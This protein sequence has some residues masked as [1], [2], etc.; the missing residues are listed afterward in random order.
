LIGNGV[1][2]V[3]KFIGWFFFFF[4]S[5]LAEAIHSVADTFNQI[6]LFIGVKHGQALESEK[7]PFGQGSA[8]YLWNLISAV[9]IFFLGFGITA[10]H[11]FHSLITLNEHPY[12]T[13]SLVGTFI[14]II[15]LIVEGYVFLVALKEVNTKRQRL[16]FFE[17]LNQSDDPTTIAVLL[18][19]GIAVLGVLLA[20]SGLWISKF[21]Q[22]ALPD[23]ITAI[24]IAFLLGFMAL[25]LAYINGRLLIG[26]AAPKT[27]E[28]MIRKFLQQQPEVEKIVKLKTLILGPERV[29]LT[30]ELELHGTAFIDRQ[31]IIND[32]EKIKNGEEPTPIL[33]D[34]SE[35]MIRLIGKG[36]N[37][38]EKRIYSRFPSIV[39]IDLE[40]N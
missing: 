18:E 2:T 38:L 40:V 6:L 35:R 5:I 25:A 28:A 3:A 27:S 19:D 4:P 15:A 11:G 37:K 34:T 13:P 36:I 7:Y 10:Y 29:K 9:G 16:G 1:I 32:S 21:F 33:F 31:Q 24:I 14:L 22:S 8:R 23:A 12:E 17:Y 39:A 26:Y 20:L 30:I